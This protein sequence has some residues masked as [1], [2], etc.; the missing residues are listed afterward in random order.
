MKNKGSGRLAGG[1]TAPLLTVAKLLQQENSR[2][3][4]RRATFAPGL[5]DLKPFAAYAP[6]GPGLPSSLSRRR[7][8]GLPGVYAREAGNPDQPSARRSPGRRKPD[9][10]ERSVAAARR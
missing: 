10:L 5:R 7:E 8:T 4:L 6:H 1:N 2:H 9:R 3:Q